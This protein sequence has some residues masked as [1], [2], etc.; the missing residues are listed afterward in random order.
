MPA[1]RCGD[2]TGGQPVPDAQA[3][4]RPFV[5]S[6]AEGGDGCQPTDCVIKDRRVTV[7]AG[8][9]GSQ[10]GGLHEPWTTAGQH[11]SAR[12]AQLPTQPGGRRVVRAS[13]L[14]GVTAHDAYHLPT[15]QG[16]RE[17]IGD[18]VVVDS[19]RHGDEII[20]T[21]SAVLEPVIGAGV[22][23]RVVTV[24]I[25]SRIQFIRGVEPTA[26]GLD[27]QARIAGEH[28]RTMGS[29]VGFEV[30]RYQPTQ[31][32][33]PLDVSSRQQLRLEVGQIDGLQSQVGEAGTSGQVGSKFCVVVDLL[34]GSS[35]GGSARR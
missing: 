27:R 1:G 23:G 19:S 3:G 17:G 15:R 13:T 11:H 26:V 5:H 32:H 10:V 4:E 22:R 30:W 20:V 35:V 2:S 24:L 7:V 8:N 33:E 34:H 18:G 9:E 31:D 29:Q 14:G 16:L 12:L 25:Q 28:N 21:D 6:P